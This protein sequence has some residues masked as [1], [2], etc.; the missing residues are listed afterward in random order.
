[1]TFEQR[2]ERD[3]PLILDDIAMGPYPDYVNDVL[4]TTAHGRQ[5]P[6]WTN[7]WSPA[8][9]PCSAAASR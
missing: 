8:R 5:R 7:R 2:F 6:G 3:L 9:A 1:M 4:S